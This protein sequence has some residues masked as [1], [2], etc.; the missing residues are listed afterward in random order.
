M[1]FWKRWIIVLPILMLGCESG[2]VLALNYQ[3]V[4]RNYPNRAQIDRAVAHG[5]DLPKRVANRQASIV[6]PRSEPISIGKWCTITC[7][8]D[9]GYFMASFSLPVMDGHNVSV[10]LL[11]RKKILIRPIVVSGSELI[12]QFS[13]VRIHLRPDYHRA[14]ICQIDRRTCADIFKGD[15]CEKFQRTIHDLKCAVFRNLKIDPRPQLP[16]NRVTSNPIGINREFQRNGNGSKA[17]STKERCDS[18]PGRG[19]PGLIRCF[20]SSDGGAP[21]GAQI[22]GVVVLGLITGIGIIVGIGREF[23]LWLSGGGWHWQ[24]SRRCRYG[25]LLS[26]ASAIGLF[27]WWI[28][29]A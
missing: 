27:S 24:C 28:S 23:G 1:E 19:S 26:A 21:L 12:N 11:P 3:H 4:V 20:L 9:V 10:P 8:N 16:F 18:R 29:A 5:Y 22:S 15:L 2:K 13:K 7:D 14:H 17:E 6:G 25:G